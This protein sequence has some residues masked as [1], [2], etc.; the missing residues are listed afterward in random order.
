MRI[1]R[2]PRPADPRP[3]RRLVSARGPALRGTARCRGGVVRCARASAGRGDH[4]V[5]G[6]GCAQAGKSLVRPGRCAAEWRVNWFCSPV[7]CPPWRAFCLYG[8]RCDNVTQ[9][10]CAHVHDVLD[11]RF[12]YP[13][14]SRWAYFAQPVE[15][16]IMEQVGRREL[17]RQTIAGSCGNSGWRCLRRCT[18]QLSAMTPSTSQRCFARQRRRPRRSGSWKG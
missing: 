3:P 9:R 1:H 16:T 5:C 2:G 11:E 14:P 12:N 18:Q 10:S 4:P 13:T 15:M 6:L 8:R 7:A 17:R